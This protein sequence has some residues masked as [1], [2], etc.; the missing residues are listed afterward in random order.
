MQKVK[1]YIQGKRTWLLILIAILTG[2]AAYAGIPAEDIPDGFSDILGIL[3][4][5]N[6]PEPVEGN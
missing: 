2:L 4:E 1:S 3:K 6:Q 5:M